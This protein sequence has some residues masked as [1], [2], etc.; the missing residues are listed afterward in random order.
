MRVFTTRLAAPEPSV[1]ADPRVV[2]PSKKVTVL[3]GVELVAVTVPVSVTLCANTD[4]LGDEVS[5][6][7][8]DARLTA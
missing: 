5:V 1:C 8:V 4:G 2:P 3:E 7:L 6:V